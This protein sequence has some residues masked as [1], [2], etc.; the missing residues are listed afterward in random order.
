VPA[1]AGTRAVR[2]PSPPGDELTPDTARAEVVDRLLHAWQARLT[3]SLSPAALMLPFVDWAIHLANAPGEQAALVEKAMR[4][5]TRFGLYLAHSAVAKETPPCIEPLPQ[6]RPIP[7]IS[8]SRTL[9]PKCW[10][11]SPTSVTR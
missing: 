1:R 11:T 3:Y 7:R 4:K 2:A 6:D 8:C 10:R 9:T 5:L